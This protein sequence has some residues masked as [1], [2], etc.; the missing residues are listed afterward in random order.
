MVDASWL[1]WAP[2]P[3]IATNRTLDLRLS[4][5]SGSISGNVLAGNGGTTELTTQSGSQSVSIYTVGVSNKSDT[6]RILTTSASGSQ[7]LT[8]ISSN[9]GDATAIEAKHVSTQSASLNIGYPESWMGKVHAFIDG[10]G[11]VGMSGTDLEKSGGGRNVYGWRGDGD[12]KEVEI[13]GMGS[14]S[15]KFTC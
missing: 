4:T 14:G 9:D 15:V 1:P 5:S 7:K 10:S 3:K 12:L 6:T 2:V 13:H 8:I 11:H